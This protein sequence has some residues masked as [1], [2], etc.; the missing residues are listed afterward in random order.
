MISDRDQHSHPERVPTARGT[1]TIGCLPSA[2]PPL[3][4]ALSKRPLLRPMN[5]KKKEMFQNALQEEPTGTPWGMIAGC[6]TFAALLV[7]GY[8]L[9]T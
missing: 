8:F 1:L 3:Q 2:N 9:V 6:I 4:H 5:M 7:T